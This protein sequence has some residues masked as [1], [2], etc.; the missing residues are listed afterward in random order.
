VK[1]SAFKVTWL[2]VSPCERNGSTV[3][4]PVAILKEPMSAF[5]QK[6]TLARVRMM[7]A[8]LPPKADI[9]G[10]IMGTRPS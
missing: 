3:I 5:G 2:T 10:A 1:V 6:Q 7:P 4:L 9:T 8:A